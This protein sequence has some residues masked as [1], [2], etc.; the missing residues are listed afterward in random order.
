MEASKTAEQQF[1]LVKKRVEKMT[2]FYKHLASYVLVN[3]FLSTLFIIE[4]V[5]DG[6]TF[7]TALTAYHNYKIWCFWGIGIVFQ[8]FNT[9]GL[10]LFLNK[11][12]EEKKIKEYLKN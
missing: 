9:F 11:V 12:W 3:V 5:K 6:D 8:A 2:S 4:D 10:N 7:L 1:I